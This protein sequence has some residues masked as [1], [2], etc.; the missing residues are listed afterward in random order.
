MHEVIYESVLKS[1]RRLHHQQ[2][3]EWL[4]EFSDRRVEEYAG[5]I[6][7]HYE[8]A[9]Q[10]TIA[11]GW[12][13][14]AG[15]QAQETY[16]TDIALAYFQQALALYEQSPELIQAADLLPVYMGLGTILREKAQFT[17]ALN[18][19]MLM[20]ETAEAAWSLPDRAQALN[21]LARVYE[22]LGDYQSALA[23]AEEM[24]ICV[25]QMDE[26][27]P[28]LRNR[29][30]FRKG[31]I[32]Y[33]MGKAAE[34]LEIAKQNLVLSAEANDQR[35]LAQSLSF[36]ASVYVML[37][38]FSEAFAA[39]EEALSIDR[40][41][42]DP[43]RI[44]V[45]LN[46]LGETARLQGDYKR[47]VTLYQEAIT[48]VRQIGNLGGE[49]VYL[50]NLAGARIGLGDYKKAITDLERVIE[51]VDSDWFLSHETQR[52]FAQAYLGLGR[53]KLAV[54]AAQKALTLSLATGD[55]NGTGKTWRVLGEIAARCGRPIEIVDGQ[56]E[57]RFVDAAE[58]YQESLAIFKKLALRPSQA[59][60]L[61]RWAS[62]ELESGN[63]EEGRK[64]WQQAR[65]IFDQLKLTHWLAM[66]DGKKING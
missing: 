25:E 18:Y 33:R 36:L 8:R 52:F 56:N 43:R 28:L 16:V 49:M 24:G 20:R 1:Q 40:L 44:A 34:A 26:P 41:S 50:S 3:A 60:V 66:M 59:R 30:L 62:H 47:A 11:A 39:L 6:A 45:R 7:R 64:M 46:N 23:Y 15:K 13:T 5:L 53:E 37:G 4:I 21:G 55:Q 58:C 10:E 17:E 14:R 29:A 38:Q 32:L 27:D 61:W 35:G 31:W 19:F 12:Y 65:E 57:T 63:F 54:S 48:V 9:G 42:G 51:T 2:T 22:R